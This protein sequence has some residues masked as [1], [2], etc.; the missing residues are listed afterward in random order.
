MRTTFTCLLIAVSACDTSG[1]TGTGE[2][3]APL[4]RLDVTEAAALEAV[5]PDEA[6]TPEADMPDVMDATPDSD[7]DAM[8]VTSASAFSGSLAFHPTL[9]FAWPTDTGLELRFSAGAASCEDAFAFVVLQD[10]ALQVI[11]DGEGGAIAAGFEREDA[12]M[13]APPNPGLTRVTWL[14]TAMDSSL[15]AH[16]YHLSVTTRTPTRLVG[17]LDADFDERSY[18][19]FAALTTGHLEGH[20]DVPICAPLR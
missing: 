15:T 5:V 14:V 20:F 2:P 1:S 11:I 9:A 8:P 18:E 3:D 16:R 13:F 19:P 7:P 12:D 17:R 4:D 6:Q 10:F